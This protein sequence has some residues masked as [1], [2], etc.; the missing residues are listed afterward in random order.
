MNPNIL[1]GGFC[2]GKS[3]K[4]SNASKNNQDQ[5]CRTRN[6]LKMS[7]DSSYDNLIEEEGMVQN[8]ILDFTDSDNEG[9]D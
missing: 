3:N 5:L 2:H 8:H 9:E 6:S 7:R 1:S 4:H